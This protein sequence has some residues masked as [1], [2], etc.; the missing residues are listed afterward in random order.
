MV[1]IV[2]ATT[3]DYMIEVRDSPNGIFGSWARWTRAPPDAQSCWDVAVA[4]AV[5]WKLR[6]TFRPGNYF[7]RFSYSFG[8][9]V[10]DLG[11]WRPG[12]YTEFRCASHEHSGLPWF[13]NKEIHTFWKWVCSKIPEIVIFPGQ[14]PRRVR[15]D[16]EE[17][18]RLT[19]YGHWGPI[20]GI[21]M[22]HYRHWGPINWLTG[23]QSGLFSSICALTGPQN[24]LF[25][26]ILQ[27][28]TYSG[29]ISI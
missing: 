3:D 6:S 20:I 25:S 15:Q 23:P 7:W 18:F 22:T 13:Q 16:I 19:E 5:T 12:F 21:I 26:N 10:R 8:L 9:L 2:P 24:G 14:K 17:L 4:A 29:L 1:Q 27:L 11:E 28:L